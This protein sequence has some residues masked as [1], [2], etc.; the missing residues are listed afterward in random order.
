MDKRR[1]YT[2]LSFIVTTPTQKQTRYQNRQ[3][4]KH[5]AKGIGPSRAEESDADIQLCTILR[6]NSGHYLRG[7]HVPHPWSPLIA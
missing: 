5:A 2:A 6:A 1:D 4:K 3:I 7:K